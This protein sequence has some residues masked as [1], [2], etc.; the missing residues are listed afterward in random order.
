MLKLKPSRSLLEKAAFLA[1]LALLSCG[2]GFAAS[3]RGWF[4]ND[5]VVTAWHQAQAIVDPDSKLPEFVWERTYERQGVRIADGDEVQ[6]GLTLISSTWRDTDWR[7]GLKL[8]DAN[9]HTVHR[10]RLDPGEVFH[11]S[12]TG[13]SLDR[14]DGHGSHLFPNGDLLVNIEP[15]GTVRLDACSRVLWRLPVGSHHSIV[16]ADDG[17][18]WIPG[19]THKSAATSPDYPDGL[20][21]LAQD[22]I[23]HDL[24][25]NVSED[26]EVLETIN[27]LDLLYGNGLERYIVKSRRLG[28]TDIA[29]LNDIEPLMAEMANDYPLFKEGDLVV[30]LRNVDLVFVFDPESRRVKWHESDPFLSQ[31]DPDFIGDGWIGVFDNNKDRTKRGT[32]LGGS[33]IVAVQPHTGA[34]EVLFPTE[35]SDVFYTS[36]MGKWQKLENGNLLLTE[37]VAGRVVEVAPD[38][39]TVWEWVKKPYDEDHVTEVDEATRYD[40]TRAD[41]ATWQC[42]RAGAQ[43]VGLGGHF[44]RP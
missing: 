38:G 23:V 10:W 4:P 29:H 18:F 41:V 35:R 34:V 36:V 11:D 15:V 28:A 5:L 17:S 27:L 22:T 3:A 37:S 32:L 40:L 13:F 24:L 19:S 39:R 7:P 21:G 44:D 33:R 9:G 16:R 6:P 31:H 8:I 1:S 20:P 30:S 12:V 42:A 2:Y 25:V 43:K 26:G 14:V